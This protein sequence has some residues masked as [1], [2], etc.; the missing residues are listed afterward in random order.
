MSED[1]RNTAPETSEEWFLEDER[2]QLQ[3][4]LFRL[5]DQ[6]EAAERRYQTMF[7]NALVGLFRV[8]VAERRLTDANLEAA[9]IFG[10]DSPVEAIAWINDHRDS[11]NYIAR[12][13]EPERLIGGSPYSFSTRATRRDG[14]VFWAQFSVRYTEDGRSVE[15]AVKDIS[16]QVESMDRLRQAKAEAEEAN[17]AKSRFLATVSHEI[18]TPLNGV[19]GFAE[20]I[21]GDPTVDHREYSRKI[22]DE[23]DRLM[24]LINQILDFSKLEANKIT[25]E[26]ILYDFRGVLG[27]LEDA[28]RPTI[29]AK[30]LVYRRDM[31]DSTP[32]WFIGDALRL[33]SYSFDIE[34]DTPAVLEKY[35]RSFRP[36]G[37]H[38]DFVTAPDTATLERTL[39]AYQQSFQKS[40]G[41]TF[42][43]ILRVFLIDTEQRIRN[44]Y[45]TA[46]LHA[47][48]VAADVRTLLIEAGR[49]DAGAAA[50]PAHDTHGGRD[51]ADP[52]L[53]LPPDSA[54][55]G[56]RPTAAQAALGARLFF[57]RRLSHN[58]TISCAM[59]H[60]PAQ[61]FTVNELA[62]AVGVEGR[63]VKRNAPTL[64]N[65]A[66][67]DRLFHDARE[68]RLEHQVWS[69]LLAHNEM[70]NPSVGYVI[71]NLSQWSGY[72]EAFREAFDADIDME[73]IG[74]ALAAYQRTLVAG[75]SPFDRWHFGGEEDAVDAA[76]KRGFALFR[77]KAGCIACHTMDD[78]HALFTDQALHNTGIG[79]AASMAPDGGQRNAELAPGTAI[80]YDLAY[81][82]PSA[83]RKPNDLGRYEVTQDPDDRWKYRTPGLRNVALTRPYMHDGSLSTLADVVAFYN[84]GGSPNELLDPLIRP[85][86]LSD[87]EQ[88]DLVAFLQ[89]LTSPAVDRLVD[90]AQAVTISNPD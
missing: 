74:A 5:E 77:G 45:S 51:P 61:G 35:A 3:K 19:I 10:F 70:A 34:H 50:Q 32:N 38:W 17:E 18:R 36:E 8:D 81:V 27:E 22:L 16:D 46:F 65:S 41:H 56:P 48:T 47:D 71:D 85:L 14:G 20:I 9:R 49:L 26:S 13:P 39:A 62:T 37:A 83:E 28:L 73:S 64:L 11:H 44:I 87:A 24:L 55:N 2:R 59:C 30:G 23:S 53:G 75:G 90:A 57:D 89:S 68:T 66:W 60:V 54:M 84:R 52:H 80:A 15:G 42:A 78:G 58:R 63:T 7:E 1:A 12:M 67:L 76:V 4:E 72:R 29:E 6:K 79:Y 43:H 31:D 69:P 86:G 33:V 21:A 88:A 82:A 40:G 25:L